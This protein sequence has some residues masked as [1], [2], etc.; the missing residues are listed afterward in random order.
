MEANY[1]ILVFFVFSW[2]DQ[3]ACLEYAQIGCKREVIMGVH[4]C[5]VADLSRK[6][7]FG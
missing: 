5:V 1:Q 6:F 2:F 3:F 4:R 7:L